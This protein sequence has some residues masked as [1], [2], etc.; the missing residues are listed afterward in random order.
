MNTKQAAIGNKKVVANV[1]FCLMALWLSVGVNARGATVT[2][3]PIADTTVVQPGYNTL[4]LYENWGG[5][6]LIS[7]TIYGSNPV[8]GAYGLLRFNLS[9]IPSDVTITSAV[10]K[11]SAG[12]GSYSYTRGE[13]LQVWQLASGNAGWVEG[14]SQIATGTGATGAYLNQ[15]SYTNLSVNSGTNWASGGRFGPEVGDLGAEVGT[16]SLGSGVVLNQVYSITLAPSAVQAWLTD[17]SLASAGLA[18]HMTNNGTSSGN[19]F[20]FFNSMNSGLESALLPQLEIT[21][22]SVPEPGTFGLLGLGGCMLFAVYRKRKA[23]L[24]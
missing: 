1:V 22:S 13:T 16:L 12:G 2:L 24:S 15:T 17:S 8:Y 23:R 4:S 3:N 21:Y 6:S 11:M 7:A 14:T 18:F 9:T 19:T 5:S 20:L 10:L